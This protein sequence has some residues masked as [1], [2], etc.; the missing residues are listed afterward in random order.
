MKRSYT[1]IL[2]VSLMALPLLGD[3]GT[4][5]INTPHNLSAGGTGAIH[6]SS[7]QQ[8]CIFCHT[9]H[10]ARPQT[11]LWNRNDSANSYQ[12]YA[13]HSLKAL[14]DQP[15]GASKL[16]LSC[17]DG[18][19]A[20]G[21]V[22][23]LNQSIAM[24]GGITT[25]PPGAS[26]IGTDLSDDHPISFTYDPNLV[27]L[28][29][30]L[31]PPS[32]LP[33]SV[34]LDANSEMQCTSCHDAHNNQY[35]NF[36]VMNNANSQ[37]CNSCHITGPTN[38]PSHDQCASC[39]QPHSA[40][41]GPYLL[42]GSTVF[43]TCAKCHTGQPGSG[44][45]P[46]LSADFAKSSTHDTHSAVNLINP[47]PNNISCSDCHEPHTMTNA[48]ASAPNVQGNFGTQ[49]GVNASGI[50]IS[51]V[52]Y[53]YEVCFKCHADNA[54]VAPRVS[55]QIVQNNTRLEFNSSAISFHPV[56]SAGKNPNVPSLKAGFNTSSIIYC[57]DCHNTNSGTTAGGNGPDGPHGS[58]QSPLLIARYDTADYTN[59]SAQAYA[60]CYRCHD[61]NS[62]LGDN[63]FKEHKMHIVDERSPCSSCHDSHGIASSQGNTTNNSHLINFDTS[64][65]FPRRGVIEFRDTGTYRGSCTLVCHGERHNR[66][67]Y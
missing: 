21:S 42:S 31:T 48:V 54:A 5:I 41:S 49:S 23:S 39:H 19:I 8:V 52:Q 61:R 13:S 28:N 4:S 35:G 67:R 7:E 58:T 22:T 37:L 53:Q 6:A 65:V 51:S 1:I 33:T 63:S 47:L 56:Q 32:Q 66:E 38:V 15:T 50:S 24:V 12:I 55:R 46:N 59:E 25:L 40:P 43:D 30:K 64:I 36:M 2:M 62:I 18:T 9:P 27:L 11:Q 44:S 26:N 57:T 17:H 29:P 45:A 20:L 3:V 10:N 14:P 60:L 16:C 34:R